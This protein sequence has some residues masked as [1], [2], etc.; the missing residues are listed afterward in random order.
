MMESQRFDASLI[1]ISM[2]GAL[3]LIFVQGS[4]PLKPRP[5]GC[6]IHTHLL[7]LAWIVLILFSLGRLLCI[8]WWRMTTGQKAILI[9][10]DAC[11]MDLWFD[12]STNKH[13]P[14]LSMQLMS[15]DNHP[16][17]ASTRSNVGVDS[18]S[19]APSSDM[20][21]RTWLRTRKIAFTYSQVRSDLC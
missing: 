20:E 15:F 16:Y 9:A 1:S 21:G 4:T 10:N 3:G 6:W 14:S 17:R 18:D 7:A 2:R 11:D 8:S 12:C 5:Y 19:F 13:V